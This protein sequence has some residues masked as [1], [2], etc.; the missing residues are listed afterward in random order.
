M[1]GGKIRREGAGCK[2]RVEVRG[3]S[4]EFR[5]QGRE[6]KPLR[7]EAGRLLKSGLRSRAML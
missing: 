4:L 6:K 2:Q 7:G 1:E 3:Q 5:G